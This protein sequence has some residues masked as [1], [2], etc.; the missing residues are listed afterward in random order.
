MSGGLDAWD[1]A[2]RATRRRLSGNPKQALERPGAYFDKIC[3][4]ELEKREVFVP[5]I[6]EKEANLG[7]GDAIRQGL[8]GKESLAVDLDEQEPR[9]C[10]YNGVIDGAT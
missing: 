8:F 9:S 6:A 1:A 2:L 10:P 3:V 7:V 4:Q 5:T